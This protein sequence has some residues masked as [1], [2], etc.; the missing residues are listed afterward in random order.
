MCIHQPAISTHTHKSTCIQMSRPHICTHSHTHTYSLSLSLSY[1][2]PHSYIWVM[3][4]AHLFMHLCIQAV[5][6]VGFD[7]RQGSWA[8]LQCRC[9]TFVSRGYLQCSQAECRELSVCLFQGEIGD[10]SCL[11][12]TLLVMRSQEMLPCS[13][14]FL[15]SSL[16]FSL[17]CQSCFASLLSLF[18]LFLTVVLLCSSISP[19]KPVP[20]PY[21]L[22]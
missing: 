2:R 1:S 22:C 7:C 18:F 8:V 19:L 16:F 11:L 17:S 20:F 3:Q 14:V 13:S 4:Q 9:K 15:F 10:R 12:G 21:I 5:R 6:H